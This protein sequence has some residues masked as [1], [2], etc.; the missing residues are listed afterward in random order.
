MSL[1]RKHFQDIAEIFGEFVWMNEASQGEKG[2]YY[3]A[4]RELQTEMKRFSH[5]HNRK[6]DRE[7]FDDAVEAHREKLAQSYRMR[8]QEA[9]ER[10]ATAIKNGTLLEGV[11]I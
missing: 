8:Q 1:T 11:T 3:Q 9:E 5:R 6:F 2:G 4:G 7:R 10:R